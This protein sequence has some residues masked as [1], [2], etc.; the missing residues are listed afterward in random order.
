MTEVLSHD[1]EL[2]P[3]PAGARS[4]PPTYPPAP[5]GCGEGGRGDGNRPRVPVMERFI[6]DELHLALAAALYLRQTLRD[7]ALIHLGRDTNELIAAP[8]VRMAVGRVRTRLRWLQVNS[9][10]NF[11]WDSA[12]VQ[13]FKLQIIEMAERPVATLELEQR[14]RASY[15]RLIGPSLVGEW[16]SAAP[17]DPPP[18]H[19]ARQALSLRWLTGRLFIHG[20]VQALMRELDQP[21]N[22]ASPEAYQE[23][24]LNPLFALLLAAIDV[25]YAPRRLRNP[26]PGG[27]AHRAT[28]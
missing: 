2:E 26:Q 27:G 18:Y 1:K 21:E 5:P 24:V 9:L 3:L 10:L 8:R 16:K 25:S 13:A 4:R 19:H 20:I 12:L 15:E 14:W 6:L 7:E 28:E 11:A 23:A 17:E 22:L